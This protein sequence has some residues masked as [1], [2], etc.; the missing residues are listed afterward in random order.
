MIY[1]WEV[2]KTEAKAKAFMAGII[3]N[4]HPCGYGTHLKV[5]QMPDGKWLVTG[6]RYSSC[7]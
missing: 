1:Y 3:A 5:E 7:D 2:F 6:S 4:Y